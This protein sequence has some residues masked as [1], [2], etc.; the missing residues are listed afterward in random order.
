LDDGGRP[1]AAT[2]GRTEERRR[3]DILYMDQ[4]EGIDFA[5]YLVAW[6]QLTPYVAQLKESQEYAV[7]AALRARAGANDVSDGE[8]NLLAQLEW[9]HG[10]IDAAAAAAARAV[11]M[12]PTQPLNAFEQ[13]MVNFAHLR[14]ASGVWE[15][16]QWQ[17]RTR[18]AYQRTFDL[19]ARNVRRGITWRIRV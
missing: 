7:E 19:D 6:P 3:P 11:A 14:R 10:E 1:V 12:Q 18:D 9:Q 2:P 15:R 4:P 13:A 17:R 8:L 5:A 16:W